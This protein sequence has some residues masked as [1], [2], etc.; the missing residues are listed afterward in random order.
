MAGTSSTRTARVTMPKGSR[1]YYQ[2][3]K[4][5]QTC[6]NLGLIVGKGIV[7]P[8]LDKVEAVL[9]FAIPQTKTDVRAI[10]GLTGCYRK[11]IPDYATIALPLTDLTKKMTPNQVRW[12]SH[13]E[14]A[15]HK[16]KAL[17]YSSLVLQIPDF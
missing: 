10:L 3:R 2:A 16:L 1:A 9:A 7:R 14:T 11:F 15:F 8:A 13:C 6:N 4:C 17:L 12:Y 5:Q